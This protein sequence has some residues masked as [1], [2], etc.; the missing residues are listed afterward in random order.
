VDETNGSIKFN[1]PRHPGEQVDAD[2]VRETDIDSMPET[3]ALDVADRVGSIAV[4]VAGYD[5]GKDERLSLGELASLLNLS[6]DRAYQVF[7][8][9]VGHL[10][11]NERRRKRQ[12]EDGI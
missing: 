9:A 11:R 2:D 1:F 4:Q 7:V 6:Y 12:E 8:E 3:C 5:P 10:Q